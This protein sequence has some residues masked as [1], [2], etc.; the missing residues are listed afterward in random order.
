MQV[1]ELDVSFPYPTP[2]ALA[3]ADDSLRHLADGTVAIVDGLAFGAMPAVVQRHAQRLLFVPI[4]HLPLAEDVGLDARVAARLEAEERLALESARLVIVTGEQT[5]EFLPR[6]GVSKSRIVLAEP[7]ADPAPLSRGSRSDRLG[8]LCV[9]TV[10]PGKGHAML[11]R[12]LAHVPVRQWHLVCVGSLL[13]HPATSADL[14]RVLGEHDLLDHVSLA[15]EMSGAELAHVYEDA[16]LFVL[17]TMKETFGMAVAEAIAHGL[18]VVSTTTGAIPR[19]VGRDAGLLVPPGDEQAFTDALTR[20][21][22]DEALRRRL[23]DGARE[24][25]LRL[26]GWQQTFHTIAEALDGLERH[27]AA[28]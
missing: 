8:L 2:A 27:S 16:D 9:A 22:T 26:R 15:G 21:L 17:P 23:R 6:Y 28:R 1:L 24:A 11:I 4:I 7:G 20:V 3:H 5:K 18:P 12:A 19:I 25:R 14:R 13:R 10:N